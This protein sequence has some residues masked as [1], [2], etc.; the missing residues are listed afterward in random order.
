MTSPSNNRNQT[1]QPYA[2]IS[3]IRSNQQ[4][5]DLLSTAPTD[6]AQAINQHYGY[7]Q[8]VEAAV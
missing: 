4:H 6:Y 8:D 7:T 5:F 1:R 2:S 3:A